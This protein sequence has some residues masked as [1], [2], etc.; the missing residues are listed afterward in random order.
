MSRTQGTSP[1]I[2][3][4]R[5]GPLALAVDAP[6][7]EDRA[8]IIHSYAFRRLQGKTQVLGARGGDFYRTRL[9]HSLE[10][11]ELG[12]VMLDALHAR[13]AVWTP[14]IPSHTLLANICLAHDLGHPPFGHAG[15]RTL[16]AA[17]RELNLA[18]LDDPLPVGFEANGQTLRLLTHLETGPD[19]GGYGLNLTRRLL[20][21]VLKYPVAYSRAALAAQVWPPKCYLDTEQP[22][23]DW[24]LAPLS[25]A[26]R[27]RLTR[28]APD[29]QGGSRSFDSRLMELADDAAYSIYDLEDGVN[30]G[31]INWENWEALAAQRPDLAGVPQLSAWAAQIFSGDEA[32]CKRGVAAL[33][34][35]LVTGVEVSWQGRFEEPL[36]DL[37]ADFTPQAAA[38]QT[39][40]KVLVYQ[41]V[42]DTPQVRE[43]EARASALLR[44]LFDAAQAEPLRWLGRES[45]RRLAGSRSEA[46]RARVVC[47][48][49][50]GMTDSYAL[51]LAGQLE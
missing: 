10:V 21:G 27:E 13:P 14:Q 9:T 7:S 35:A 22:V 25:A 34:R 51:A 24:L 12:R 1:E 40:L 29:P 41:R 30:L 47:D 11:A 37:R 42:I 23:V 48:Y 4:A 26:D 31:L 2:W 44:R 17:M 16:D 5:R 20:L 8:W 38:L 28:P 43:P 33:S 50:A 36:L 18:Y 49:L 45:R 15:E 39:F 46:G 32:G 3:E 19:S 6:E